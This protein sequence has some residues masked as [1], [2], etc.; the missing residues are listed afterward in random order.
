MLKLKQR[1][2]GILLRQLTE[3][4]LTTRKCYLIESFSGYRSL[5]QSMVIDCE[6]IPS[7]FQFIFYDCTWNHLNLTLWRQTITL[8]VLKYSAR[9]AQKTKHVSAMKTD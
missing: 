1:N 7:A 8:I 2:N 6:A 5:V 4:I 3:C 9:T